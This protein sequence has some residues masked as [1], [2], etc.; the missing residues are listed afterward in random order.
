MDFITSSNAVKLLSNGPLF[1]S[2]AS[3]SNS[4]GS[5]QEATTESDRSSVLSLQIDLN[6]YTD[7]STEYTPLS[8]K[9]DYVVDAADGVND[10]AAI[11]DTC[12][13]SATPIVTSGGVGGLTD[14]TLIR[15]NDLVAVTGDSLLMR[16][17]KK[18]RQQYGYPNNSDVPKNGG[19]SGDSS[20]KS[21]RSAKKKIKKWNILGVH[22]LP[23]G[24]QRGKHAVGNTGT[25]DCSEAT[26][27]RK[28]D[29]SFGNACFA[30]GTVGMMIASVVVN[31]VGTESTTPPAKT[32]PRSYDRLVKKSSNSTG[33]S[34]S[35]SSSDSEESTNSVEA[36]IISCECGKRA[37]CKDY[38]PTLNLSQGE[39]VKAALAPLGPTSGSQGTEGTAV[40]SGNSGSNSNNNAG[41]S[42]ENSDKNGNR[43]KSESQCTN[44]GS[45]I[46]T[47]LYIDAHSH[48][49]I[50]E[51]YHNYDEV[52]A[53]A[54][55]N[56]IK[57]IVI[58]G[59]MP[60]DDWSKVMDCYDKQSDLI[61]PNFGLH[62]WWIQ[63]YYNRHTL[64]SDTKSSGDSSPMKSV[65]SDEEWL[66]E[67]ESMLVKYPFASVGEC[68]IDAGI[69]KDV[70]YQLQEKII[71][72][73]LQLAAKYQ[74]TLTLHCVGAWGHL[75]NILTEHVT[76]EE[77]LSK[78]QQRKQ[79][80][81][82]PTFSDAEDVESSTNDSN[83]VKDDKRL[84][85]NPRAIILHS[86]HSMSAESVPLFSRFPN[87][88]FSVS[89]RVTATP[90]TLK[91]LKAIPLD[92]LLVETDSPDQLPM[93]L[94][95]TNLNSSQSKQESE[96]DSNSRG[97]TYNEPALLR[98]N[99]E[100]ISRA[101]SMS[102]EDL[103]R[104]TTENAIKAFNC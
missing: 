83:N 48:L 77:R 28:C 61:I 31:S 29:V 78:R 39:A 55:E 56:N 65:E 14:P 100:E 4:C 44:D 22:T 20:A 5:D 81:T 43:V 53:R 46:D 8:R 51:L 68:G 73:H 16:V 2:E 34:S 64:A 96:R 97:I 37:Q 90:K 12:V 63:R 67:L 76:V 11:I 24:L 69:K 93:S 74:R 66:H 41:K 70:S 25:D 92:R 59:V 94:W 36:G 35:T 19:K 3:Q 75:L 42:S 45:G 71:V 85:I 101:L 82:F 27:F 88:F 9:F 91:V 10:K 38:V 102:R 54:R 103:A 33:S 21:V 72:Q 89:G 40:N 50:D 104:I 62:P 49:Q 47:A 18:L 79:F 98:Y 57:K 13:R 26:S 86:C 6:D 17:R 15:I 30:T 58:C 87:T 23:T 52:I 84:S 32:L 1:G 99:C 95:R 7:L 60:G 80:M